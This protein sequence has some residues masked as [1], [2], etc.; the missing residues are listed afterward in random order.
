MKFN[1]N[2]A[3]ERVAN[4][5]HAGSVFGPAGAEFLLGAQVVEAERAWMFA[6]YILIFVVLNL[7]AA[8]IA[9]FEHDST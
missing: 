1:Y 2:K 3:A 7:I 8:V 9:A 4:A 6:L 5:F